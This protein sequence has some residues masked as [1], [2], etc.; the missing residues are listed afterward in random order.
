MLSSPLGLD[1]QRRALIYALQANESEAYLM[2]YVE[3]LSAAD[4]FINKKLESA[5]VQTLSEMAKALV[6]STKQGE[7]KPT[8]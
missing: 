6:N 5:I 7:G 4:A 8:V 1:C 2:M 3:A